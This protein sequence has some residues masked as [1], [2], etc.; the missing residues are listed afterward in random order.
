MYH[1]SD[2]I[3]SFQAE[4]DIVRNAGFNLIGVTQFM[5]YTAFIFETHEEAMEAHAALE[6]ID[7]P[8]VSGWWYG[9]EELPKAIHIYKESYPVND[10]DFEVKIFWL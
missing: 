7:E 10:R 1:I 9:K 2:D 8:L 5:F 4:I 6:N 3:T